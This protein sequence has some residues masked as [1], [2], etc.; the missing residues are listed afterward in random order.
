[1]SSADLGETYDSELLGRTVQIYPPNQFPMPN[2]ERW[3]S[4]EQGEEAKGPI[5]LRPLA[6]TTGH[7]VSR[8]PAW[9]TD[10]GDSIL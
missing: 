1:M 9:G 6:G 5:F 3:E 8:T 7:I 10:S 4:R 2:K